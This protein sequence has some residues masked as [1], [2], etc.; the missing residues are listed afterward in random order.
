M[1]VTLTGKTRDLK[2]FAYKRLLELVKR[3]GEKPSSKS[4]KSKSP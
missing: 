1:Y 2:D 3:L 4:E